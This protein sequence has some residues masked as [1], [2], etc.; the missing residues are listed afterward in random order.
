MSTIRKFAAVLACTA[1]VSFV[2]ATTAGAEPGGTCKR[3][4]ALSGRLDAKK[5]RLAARA[6]AHPRA[7]NVGQ[8][9][10]ADRDTK[11]QNKIAEIQAR[12]SS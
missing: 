12:C 11:V 1:L 2:G 9:H 6:S 7:A 3:V 5:A 4:A 8:Q 10:Q